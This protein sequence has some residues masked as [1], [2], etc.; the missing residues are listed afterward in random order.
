MANKVEILNLD[1][2][3]SALISKMTDTRGEIEK[4]K[5]AQ[6]E[7]TNANLAS[8]D[9]FTK[10]EVELK[11]LQSE[12]S[13]Q[14]NIVTQLNTAQN[15]FATATEAT[16]QAVLKENVSIAAARENNKQLITLRNQLN[17]ST[18]EGK[19]SLN[20][21]NE[22]LDANNAYIKANV[23]GYEKQKIGIG[24]YRTAITG[25]LQDTGLFGGKVQAAT[26][27]L[28][29]FSGVFGSMKE[30]V[31][32]SVDQIRNSATATD[33]MTTAQKALSIA[34]AVGTGAMRIF[35]LALAATGIGIIIGAVVL[36]IGYFKTFDP[37]VDK[38]EQGMAA[39]GAVVRVVQQALASL[40]D[41]T[42]DS[43]KSFSELGDNM[44]KAAKDA[45]KLKAAQQDLQDLQNSQEVANAKASQQY[46]ELILKSKNR[47][48]TEKE[49]IAFLVKAEAIETA[50]YK[51]RAALAQTDLNQSIESA[52]IK[53][54][55]SNQELSNLQRNTI[56]YGTYLLNQGKITDAELEAL[57]K[58]ELGKIAIDAE[59]TKRLEKNQNA[60]D[61]LNDDA[62][63]KREKAQQ[64]ATAAEQ[65]RLAEQ[66][67]VVDAALRKSKE[68]IDLFIAKQG[69]KKKSLEDELVFEQ[70]LLSKKQALLKQE[71]DNK[72]ISQLAY[73]SESLKLKNEFAKKQADVAIANAQLELDEYKRSIDIK[74]QDE[75]FFT[76]QKLIQK[77]SEND[78]LAI[79]EIEFQAL[80]LANGQI[81]ETDYNAAV[82]L[83]NADNKVKNDEA[84]AIREQAKKDKQA[85][86][87]ENQR[88]LDEEKFTSDF[89]LQTQRENIRYQDEL[90]A[91]EKT[92]ADTTLIKQKHANAQKQIDENLQLSKINA[93]GATAG[94]VADLLGKETAAGKAAALAQALINTYL[95]IAAGVKLGYPMAIPAVAMAAATGFAAVKNIVSTKVPSKAE[96]GIIPTLRSGVINNGSNVIPLSNG[97]DT[98][99]YVKQGEVILNEQQQRAAGGSMFFRSIGVPNFNGG[100]VVGGNSNLGRQNGFKID[101]DLLAAK[102]AQAN[103]MLPAPVVSVT[104]ISYQQNRVAVI[105]NGANF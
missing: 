80:R 100:G 71:Y 59:S 8:T 5:A 57:K 14:K 87:L 33:G 68:G 32:D 2:N 83:I 53:G 103:R 47:T 52:R 1:I 99:A 36:L 76:E 11:R 63:A 89:D 29:N 97:D 40:F 65:K 90:K 50:N 75:T 98:L 4:L 95:G 26:Q 46:D 24:D 45:A 70:Q 82:N 102:M 73:E 91:A 86:D 55:L 17:T 22:K 42:Q 104:D 13:T 7:L 39:L 3:T 9:A 37:L 94:V 23:S 69:F 16:T 15:A 105:E 81:S 85:I 92:G 88:I 79:K 18:D 20:A 58:A 48:L 51:Q 74:I 60:Q 66:S 31:K 78:A 34:T 10:N 93:L 67:K 35:T 72:K 41:S 38:L 96:G 84:E 77:Q 64:D 27:T 44:A 61:K 28:S 101:I 54:G 30:Q 19:A 6:K 43:S 56:A 25:A 49:R 62:Q 21:I 12:Y